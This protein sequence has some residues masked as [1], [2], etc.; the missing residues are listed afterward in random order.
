M[1]MS[2]FWTPSILVDQN[3]GIGTLVEGSGALF[4]FWQG[5]TW[6]SVLDREKGIPRCLRSTGVW[7]LH[8]MTWT[9]SVSRGG[10]NNIHQTGGLN[11]RHPPSPGDHTSEV[12]GSQGWAPFTVSRGGLLAVVSLNGVTRAGVQELLVNELQ[13]RKK[14]VDQFCMVNKTALKTNKKQ[15]KAKSSHYWL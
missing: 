3:E 6:A 1:V 14:F 5:K 4:L 10:R 2:P 15:S 12:K 11:E 13:N 7:S 8:L 9:V